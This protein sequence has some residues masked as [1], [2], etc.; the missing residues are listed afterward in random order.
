VH[1]LGGN[2][3]AGT[4]TL[5]LLVSQGEP[6]RLANTDNSFSIDLLALDFS[7]PERNLYSWQM[8]GVDTSWSSPS[9]SRT[10]LYSSLAPGA[11]TFRFKA[12]NSD[13]VWNEK[14][15]ELRLVV[16]PAWWQ[17]WWFRVLVVL[18]IVALVWAGSEWR[19]RSLQKRATYLEGVIASR[20]S[21]L[22]ESEV[23]ITTIL[24]TAANA[25]ITADEQGRILI[26]NQGAEQMYGYTASEIIGNHVDSLSAAHTLMKASEIASELMAQPEGKQS[27]ANIEL[28]GRRKN[29]EN[30]P[31][32]AGFSSVNIGTR[33]LFTSVQQDIS[34]IKELESV[35]GEQNRTLSTKNDE[36]IR[37]DNEKNDIL[38]IVSHD[39]KNPMTSIMGLTELLQ[40]AAEFEMD[41]A[42]QMSILGQIYE[43]SQRM[44]ALLKNLLDM[45]AIESGLI[46]LNFCTVKLSS[47]AGFVMWDYQAR[48]QMKNIT[49]HF[50]DAA[51]ISQHDQDLVM[52]DEV[53]IHQVIDNL[54]S[55]AVKYSPYDK[56][57][58]VRLQRVEKPAQ[59]SVEKSVEKYAEGVGGQRPPAFGTT[60]LET[61][62]FVR[63]QI[64]DEGPGISGED[65][66]KL[67]GRFMRLSAQPTAGEHS[68]GLG[69][70][71]V[72]KIVEAMHGSVW[73]ESTIDRGASFFVEFPE[74]VPFV[75]VSMPIFAEP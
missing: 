34:R 42:M 49:L 33:R 22:R 53:K 47:I 70:S 69:L 26:F 65:M 72:K 51:N 35:L 52:V 46:Q 5:S 15:A 11:Y 64:Q 45:N 2:I 74:T 48:A 19:S 24:K 44:M 32:L 56:N 63:L 16:L 54:L 60:A 59:Q 17:T 62:F 55:N 66:Q 73:C 14:G 21:E 23:Q 3:I 10:V 7:A 31:V 28:V 43:S 57:V 6:L 38:G 41:S 18:G 20:T 27:L 12:A 25:I 71:I 1:R 40:N 58:W 8:D 39:L 9:L 29:N 36:L 50:E 13:G 61:S 68:S 37:L 67:F 30:F 4:D 75:P